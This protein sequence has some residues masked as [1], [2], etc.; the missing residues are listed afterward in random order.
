MKKVVIIAALLANSAIC[1]SQS[2]NFT[3]AQ[4]I[5]DGVKMYRQAGTCTEV[6]M[7]LRTTDKIEFRRKLNSH[8]SIVT[9]DG[10][11]GYVLHS[12]LTNPNPKP[13]LIAM[14]KRRK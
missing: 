11:V 12:E 3:Y 9:V 14:Q 2:I 10:K 6:L 13:Q 5:S 1:F 8:W 7:S 4:A